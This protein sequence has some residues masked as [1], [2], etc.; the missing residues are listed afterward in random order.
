MSGWASSGL[1]RGSSSRSRVLDRSVRN[2]PLLAVLEVDQ[3]DARVPSGLVDGGSSSFSLRHNR[4]IIGCAYR[5]IDPPQPPS[6]PRAG[7]PATT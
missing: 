5:D 6:V 7:G 2:P 3:Q 1:D 4:F